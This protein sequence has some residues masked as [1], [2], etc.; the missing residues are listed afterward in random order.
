M[1][2]EALDRNLWITPFG[3]GY[4]AAVRQNTVGSIELQTAA[5][6]PISRLVSIT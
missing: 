4:G 2:V 5:V 3:R 1:K 6:R